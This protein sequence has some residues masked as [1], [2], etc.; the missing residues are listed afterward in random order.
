MMRWQRDGAVYYSP[1][2]ERLCYYDSRWGWVWD[3]N[4]ASRWVV[5]PLFYIGQLEES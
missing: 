2:D 5:G 3:F 1:R 4:Y